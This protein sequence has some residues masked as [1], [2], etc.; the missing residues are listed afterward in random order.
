MS[1][2]PL[3]ATKSGMSIDPRV[4]WR[5]TQMSE[6]SQNI[7]KNPHFLLSQNNNDNDSGIYD[8]RLYQYLYIDKMNFFPKHII[9]KYR[10]EGHCA[11]FFLVI[12]GGRGWLMDRFFNRSFMTSLKIEIVA[13]CLENE[14]IIDVALSLEKK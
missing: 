2:C 12:I 14:L 13:L 9:L 3:L 5:C 7:T 1:Y 4:W 10:W 11:S 6:C 8:N